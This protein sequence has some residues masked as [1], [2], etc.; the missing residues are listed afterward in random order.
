ML[1]SRSLECHAANDKRFRFF[2]KDSRFTLL[3]LVKTVDLAN[4]GVVFDGRKCFV[5]QSYKVTLDI[6]GQV[7]RDR[8]IGTLEHLHGGDVSACVLDA[9]TTER[10]GDLGCG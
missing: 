4:A 7:F 2:P 3:G 9:E 10:F 1:S 8:L 5:S 6:C